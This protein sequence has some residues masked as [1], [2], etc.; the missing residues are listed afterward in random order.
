MFASLQIKDFLSL[1]Q[2]GVNVKGGRKKH[3]IST[4]E[5]MYGTASGYIDG[6]LL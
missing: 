5:D 2:P 3:H 4:D 1:P 6:A